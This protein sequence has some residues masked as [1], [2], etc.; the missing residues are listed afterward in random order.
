MTNKIRKLIV[1]LV[2]LSMAIPVSGMSAPTAQAAKDATASKVIFYAADGMRPDLMERYASEGVMPTYAGL[3]LEGVMGA[4][5]LV[6][7]FPPNTGVGWYTLATGTYPSEHGS[8]N[9]TF[10]RTGDLFNNRTAAFSAGVLQADT[11]PE[12]AERAGKKVVSVEWSGGSRTMTALKGP[13]V[14]YRNFYSNRGLWTN[15][16]VPGQPAGAN[17]FGVQYQRY[18]LA[19]ASGW[20]PNCPVSLSPGKQGTFDLGSYTSG[21]PPMPVIANDQYD[22]YVYDST[23]DATVNYDHVLIAPN[24]SGKDCSKAVAD[25]K[26][27]EWADVKLVLANPAG[28]TGGFYVKAMLLAPDLSKFSLFFSSVARSVATCTGCSYVGDFEDDLNRLFPSSTGADYAIFESGLV[29]AATYIEQ[30]LMW[31]NA[32][33]TYLRYIIGTDPV[34]T[35]DGGS[36]A[37]MGYK[38]DLLMMGSSATDEFSHMFLGLTIPSVNGLANPYYNTYASYGEVI[39]PDK[40]D[41]FIREAYM[42]A[43][44]TLALGKQLMGGNSTVFAVSD[45]GFGSQWLAVN[46]GKV[47]FDAGLQNNG[48][49]PGEVFSNCRAGGTGSLNLA[50]ACWAGG[51]AQIYVNTT[52]PA[53]KTYE[54]VRADVINA[55]ASL[56]DPANPGAQVV[57]KIMKKEELR[58]VDGSD[59]LHPNRSGDVV[60]VLKPPYQFDAAT[61]GQTIA[62]SQFFGQ[63]GYLPET[64]DF[65]SGVNM[66]ATFAAAGPGIRHQD[67]VAGIRAVDLAPT[68]SF[69]LN[70]PGPINARGKILYD[71]FPSPGQFKEATLLYISDFHGQLTPLSQAADTFSSPTYAI[72]GAAYLKPWFDVY[73]AEAT[74]FGM[75]TNYTSLTLSGGDLVGATPPISNFFGDK[76]TMTAATL[77]GLT[78]DTLGN[79]NFDRGSLYLRTELIPMAQ[80]PYLA[81]NVVYQ[82]KYGKPWPG[83]YPLEWKPSQ[84]FNFDGFK[85]GV[86]GYTLPELPTLIFPGYLD[87]FAVSDPVATINKEAA[88]LRSQGKLN[89][90]IAVGHMGG[91]GTDLFNPTGPLIDLANNLTGVDAVLGGHTHT[92]YITYLSNGMLVAESPNSGQRFTR[93]RLT[94]DTNSKKVIYKTADYHK[95]WDI[96]MTPDPTIQA[97]IDELNTELGPILNTVIGNS[98]RFIPRADACGRADG[99][100][101][102]S[103]V[104]DLAADALRKTYNTDFAITNSGGLRADLTCPTTDLPGDFCPPYT[105]P[106]YLITRGQSLAVLPFGNVVFTVSISGAELKTFLENGVS[107]MPSAQGRFPQV[108][109]LCFTYDISKPAQSRVLSAVRQAADGSCT[110]A[111]VDLTAASTYKIAENDFMATGGD[112]YPNVYAR[113]TTQGIMDQVVADYITA[114][115]PLKPAIQGRIVCTT[116]GATACPVVTP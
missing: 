58:N 112:G 28:K 92:Q 50:K 99:R 83:H 72:G 20:N 93:I 2:I 14:D 51:T 100:L 75:T 1:L 56:T 62:F 29:D 40:A 42:E 57:L 16:N 8:T 76:P 6:Q 103:L 101:C 98:T 15:W 10:F 17:A 18:D 104:G 43:D 24:A 48:A 87:P 73:R 33:W 54:G 61:F 25:L 7:A 71:L 102:E 22:F 106:P 90:I 27:K 31:K 23:D 70:I 94:V 95:P 78:A 44:A 97:L 84:V 89:A 109:G 77:M 55:F 68:I 85:L 38:P 111:P 82:D 114:N 30:G 9:N 110:G 49:T 63:H 52:L 108:S 26:E 21:T 59:S 80:F 107:L 13:V 3:M 64:V 69:L 34:P 32:H 53:G 5:G 113:G 4:N 67:P 12:A 91:D 79:H 86:I 60:V 115:T 36:K 11:L 74:G 39:T 47:L 46:A 45:H 116:S 19:E 96:G 41:G 88:R 81:V 65:A 35:V 105:Y 66:H 37:G